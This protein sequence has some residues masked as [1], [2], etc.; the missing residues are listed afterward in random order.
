M[1]GP[2]N[3]HL[4]SALSQ[5]PPNWPPGVYL[6]LLRLSLSS[7][8]DARSWSLV[9]AV[10]AHV[11]RLPPGPRKRAQQLGPVCFSNAVLPAVR[12]RTRA[13]CGRLSCWSF[14]PCKPLCSSPSITPIL[15]RSWMKQQLYDS[16]LST[17]FIYFLKACPAPFFTNLNASR[18]HVDTWQFRPG[19]NELQ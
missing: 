17:I 13:F 15:Y 4:S 1:T 8:W 5:Q 16:S 6:C 10:P 9:P 7:R 19:E 14:R 12:A 2:R 11:C 18:I 3:C